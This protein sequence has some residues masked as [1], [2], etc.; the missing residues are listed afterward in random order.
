MIQINYVRYRTFMLHRPLT[1]ASGAERKTA[2]SRDRWENY[3]LESGL[4]RGLG[5]QRASSSAAA[6]LW[7]RDRTATARCAFV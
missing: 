1:K 7:Y 6:V 2:G 5:G 4:H 3:A